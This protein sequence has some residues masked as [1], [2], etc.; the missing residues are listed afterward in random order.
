MKKVFVVLLLGCFSIASC[1]DYRAKKEQQKK[2]LDSFNI[3]NDQLKA[4][5][6][7]LGIDTVRLR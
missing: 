6:D 7:S 2:I 1:D 3:I 4:S 5:Y